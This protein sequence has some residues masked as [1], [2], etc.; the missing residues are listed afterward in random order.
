AGGCRIRVDMDRIPVFDETRRLCRLL[1][2]DPL[3]LIGSGS[4]LICCRPEDGDRLAAGIRAA[5]IRITRIGEVM[6]GKSGVTAVRDGKFV[7]WPRFEVD[8]ITRLF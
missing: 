2:I 3:G 6:E 1:G 4:L 7:P 5:N 8:E